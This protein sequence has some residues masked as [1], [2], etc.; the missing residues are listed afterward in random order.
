MT[1]IGINVV[2]VDGRGAPSITAAAVSVAGFNVVTRRGVPNSPARVTSFRQFVERTNGNL[3]GWAAAQNAPGWD[4]AWDSFLP[5]ML[6]N[7]GN[8]PDDGTPFNR[9]TVNGK[10]FPNSDPIRVKRGGRYRIVLRNGHEDGHPIHLHR[11]LFEVVKIGDKPV[12]G[13][14][15]DT[16]NVARD[17]TVEVEFVADNPGA[18]LLHC[19]MQHHMDYGFKTLLEYA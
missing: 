7:G 13:L 14:I 18:S 5:T 2:E 16:V 6:D 19:H 4:H 15:K 3:R 1:N 8:T 11:H 9:W 10:T 12:S 17:Q